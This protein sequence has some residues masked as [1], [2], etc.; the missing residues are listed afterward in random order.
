VYVR[1]SKYTARDEGRKVSPETQ[2][3]KCKALSALNDCEVEVFEDLDYSGK[4]TKRP[5]FSKLM[6]R[7][8][9]GDVSVVACYSISRLSRDVPDLYQTLKTLKQLG[10]GFVSATDPLY[11]TTSPFGEFILGIVAGVAQLERRQTSQRVAD[12]LAFK[13]SQ[14][15]LLGTLP[16]GYKREPGGRIVVDESIA[17][18]IQLVFERY[19]SGAFSYKTL[20]AWLNERGVKTIATRGGN[21]APPAALWSGDVLK[22]VLSRS[23]YTGCTVASDGALLDENAEQ[24]TIIA[25][26]LWHQV[27]AIRHRQRFTPGAE[28]RPRYRHSPFPLSR[29]LRCSCGANMRGHQTAWRGKQRRNYMCSDRARYGAISPCREP[30]VAAEPLEAAFVQ[31]LSTCHP[32]DQL[33]TAALALL[34][35]GLRQ[36]RLPAREWN[37]RRQVKELEERRRRTAMVFRM[38]LISEGQFRSE[39]EALEQQIA[40][41]KAQPAAATSQQFSARLTD[42][43]AAWQDATPEQRAQ[44]AASTVAEVTVGSGS[45]IAIRPRPAWAP[46]FEELLEVSH[47]AGDESRTRDLNVGN[48][49]LYQLSYSRVAT[50]NYNGP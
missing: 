5:G 44:L 16:T 32:E 11:D 47:G 21:G 25:R 18:T 48:V 29:L 19:A 34:E 15:K 36:R 14:G 26:D 50:G 23:S 17:A 45:M 43:V 28:R 9:V 38:G 35:R 46:Y 4:D 20:A 24:P 42:L 3:E 33:E 30:V 10:V 37:E 27:E 39:V 31:W 49:A 8:Q 12:A 40:Q 41:V 2:L 6:E 22:E 7:A 1:V 13:R